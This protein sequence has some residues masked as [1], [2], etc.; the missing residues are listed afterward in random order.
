[1]SISASIGNRLGDSNTTDDNSL[2]AIHI[3]DETAG[4]YVI[5]SINKTVK[6][7]NTDCNSD[8]RVICVVFESKLNTAIPNWA[9]LDEQTLQEKVELSGLKLYAYPESRL[10]YVNHG[11]LNGVTIN[12]TGVSDPID[13]KSGSYAYIIEE[14]D[15]EIHSESE[16]VEYNDGYVGKNSVIYEGLISALKWVNKNKPLHGVLIRTENK[17]SF[18]QLRNDYDV[19]NKGNKQ[20]M[21]EL[22]LYL[23]ELPYYNIN[24][25]PQ[26]RQEE[27][28]ELSRE[29]YKNNQKVTQ[30]QKQN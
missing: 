7:E 26:Y 23:D 21:Y 22:N 29:T 16:M 18:N 28:I 6:E 8:D 5:E 25:E 15:E 2:I 19:K 13:R 10:Y 3:P 12:I 17:L 24:L 1:M 14:D 4:E 30:V 9:F 11:L 27:L 20:L